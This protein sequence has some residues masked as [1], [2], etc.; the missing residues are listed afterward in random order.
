MGIGIV[1]DPGVQELDGTAGEKSF[2]FALDILT[3]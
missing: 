3:T 1:Q 2:C